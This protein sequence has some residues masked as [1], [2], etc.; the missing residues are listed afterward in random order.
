MSDGHSNI[1]K[2]YDGVISE[3]QKH[4]KKLK[5][6]RRNLLN[7][8][9][10][11]ETTKHKSKYEEVLG[12]SI[13][14][15]KY[16]KAKEALVRDKNKKAR[17]L[18]YTIASI[19][20]STSL[21]GLLKHLGIQAID[22]SFLH[23]TSNNM[24]TDK[25]SYWDRDPISLYT[26]EIPP[27][28]LDLAVHIVENGNQYNGMSIDEDMHLEVGYLVSSG[29]ITDNAFLEMWVSNRKYNI[30]DKACV[31]WWNAE[32]RWVSP[33]IVE[34]NLVSRI[35]DTIGETLC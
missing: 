4:I 20:L 25:K 17:I 21:A 2:Y 10:S 24:K 23:T 6:S 13:D 11:I 33:I 3:G 12:Y 1:R 18:E 9:D 5:K 7:E 22:S 26:K 8:V 30:A 15:L 14:R 32:E 27:E 28:V 35:M 19:H 31:S 34:K 16:Q 29:N